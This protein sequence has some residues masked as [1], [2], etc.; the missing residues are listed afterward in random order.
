MLRQGVSALEHLVDY[1]KACSLC[2]SLRPAPFVYRGMCELF[3][4]YLVHVYV[5]FSDV[6]LADMLDSEAAEVSVS[7]AII[8]AFI[9]PMQILNALCASAQ[10]SWVSVL[11]HSLG[12]S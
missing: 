11:A 12:F 1:K 7:C 8:I 10:S 6:S 3:D 9:N 2:R 4:M 5:A